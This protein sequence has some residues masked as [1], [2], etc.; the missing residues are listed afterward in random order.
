MLCKP[1]SPLTLA[2]LSSKE[3]LGSLI[4][5]PIIKRKMKL[6]KTYLALLPLFMHGQANAFFTATSF[7]GQS[8]ENF[9]EIEAEYASAASMMA[10]D[11]NMASLNMSSSVGSAMAETGKAVSMASMQATADISTMA[12]TEAQLSMNLQGELVGREIM[13]SRTIVHESDTKEEMAAIVKFLRRDDI[14]DQNIADIVT[15]AEKELD[16]KMQVL[17]QPI[18]MKERT[19]NTKNIGETVTLEKVSWKIEKLAKMCADNKREGIDAKEKTEAKNQTAIET[20]KTTQA[21]VEST[22]S[23]EI[24]E[25][26]QKNQKLVSCNPNEFEIGVC[27]KDMTKETYTEA[28]MNLEIIPN[29][30]ISSA[31]FYAPQSFGGAGYLDPSD[32]NVAASLE[33]ASGDA[34]APLEQGDG[35]KGLPQINYTY[36]NSK[37]LNAAK[38]FS[39]NITNA[40]AIGNQHVTER[41]KPENASFQALFLSRLASLN[42]AQSSFDNSISIRRGSELTKV[43]SG[44]VGET[45]KERR[46]GAGALDRLHHEVFEA[47]QITSA[48]KAD[49]LAASEGMMTINLLKQSNLTNKILFQDLLY[50]E[51]MELLMATL[52]ANEVNSPANVSYM[53]RAR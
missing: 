32:P 29:G 16:G 42:M 45:I 34:L 53:N 48:E 26:R 15:Y 25:L 17:I 19:E 3:L 44:T 40:F 28:V 36:R 33:A 37:Q 23:A 43:N 20:S 6:N 11:I 8:L 18:L 52:V 9:S 24:A 7:I 13:K 21:I 31:N 5:I 2:F 12:M 49:E 10:A 51:R 39:E 14:K 50:L 46:D 47:A 4:K 1:V 38:A 30:N 41:N 27:G 22:N 35:V